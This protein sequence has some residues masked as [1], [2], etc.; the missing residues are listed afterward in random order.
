MFELGEYKTEGDLL[1]TLTEY[2]PRRSFKYVGY[3]Q[4]RDIRF[5]I[6]YK[7]NGDE[8]F[9][10]K[11]LNLKQKMLADDG[12]IVKSFDPKCVRELIMGKRIP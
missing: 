3:F 12:F 4:F 9:G 5:K 8:Y 11:K 1:V 2:T 7:E 10:E 6:F